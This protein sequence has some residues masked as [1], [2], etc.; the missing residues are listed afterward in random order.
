MDKKSEVKTDVA[1]KRCRIE[2]PAMHEIV[3]RLLNFPRPVNKHF[4][5]RLEHLVQMIEPAVRQA[6]VE[7]EVK[8]REAAER[9]EK[10][11]T[12][13]PARDLLTKVIDELRGVDQFELAVADVKRLADAARKAEITMADVLER[14][15]LGNEHYAVRGYRDLAEQENPQSVPG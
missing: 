12:L 8:K 7:R 13:A 3:S 4:V 14:C 10:E 2:D 9:A 11:K 5:N 6:A 15:G 1:L